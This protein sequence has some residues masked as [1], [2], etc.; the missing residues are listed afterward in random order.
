MAMLVVTTGDTAREVRLADRATLGRH[1]GNTVRIL[2]PVVS[3]RHA[4][5]IRRGDGR[6]VLRDLGSL[7]GTFVADARLTERVLEDGDEFRMGSA[8]IRFAEDAGPHRDV[9][10]A[11]TAPAAHI[12]GRMAARAADF[13]PE[14][15]V[16][17]ETTLRRDY[18]RLRAVHELVTAVGSELDLSRLLPRI[19]DTA[20]GLLGADRG[21]ILLAEDDG[22]LI[23]RHTRTRNGPA[24]AEIT[25]SQTVL[26][27]AVEHRAAVL[28]VDAGADARFA[29]AGSVVRQGI[30]STLTLPMLHGEELLG[31]LHL[32]SLLTRRAFGDKDLAVC[33]GIAAQA[34]TAIQNA[35]LAARI[36][37]ETRARAQIARLI[38]P[39]VVEQVLS[40]ELTIERGGRLAEI[41]MLFSD[42][43]GFTAMADVTAPAE[44]VATLNE[45]F[46]VM[47][48]VLFAHS[49]TLDKF[50]GDCVIG[51]F[52]APLPLDDAPHRA[53]ACALAMQEAL[54]AHNRTRC[55]E[56]LPPINV[57]IGI[58]TGPVITGAIGSTRAMQYTAV[59]DAMNVAS[60]LADLA[61]PGEVLVAE[62]TFRNV[63]DRVEATELQ[64]VLVKG[65]ARELRRFRVTGLR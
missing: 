54:L 20:F 56:R 59:G 5:V 1:P 48:E 21:V 26:A 25:L 65:K 10:V 14:T 27:E 3:N 58:G 18:E 19:L 17:D 29:D 2:D 22:S 12:G 30:R 45:H 51:L 34:A 53:V 13:A 4:E 32:D 31:V 9:T 8:R 43:R 44:V 50:V 57:G 49:G 60:R 38:P 41:T 23:P 35:R 46:E 15:E 42:I 47:V 55:A 6:Y 7:N 11:P 16:R 39:A 37:R 61:G 28:S 63:R 52:G 33:T 40:G 62:A 24:D 36:A 64:P